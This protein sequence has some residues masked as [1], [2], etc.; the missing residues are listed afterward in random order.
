[1][2]TKKPT[3]TKDVESITT[4]A[5]R[6]PRITEKATVVA[7]QNVYTFNVAPTATKPEIVKAIKA[8][9]GVTPTKIAIVNRP[10]RKVF[11]RGKLGVKS[12]AKKAMV[13]LKKGDKIEFA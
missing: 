9:Y 11:K 2:A 10:A 13:Y 7:E 1:M 4:L 6:G 5:L 12:G 8:L 3:T